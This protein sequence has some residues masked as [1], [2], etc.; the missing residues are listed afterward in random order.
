MRRLADVFYGEATLR[1][2]PSSGQAAIS[3]QVRRGAYQE[4]SPLGALLSAPLQ[5]YTVKAITGLELRT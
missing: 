1:T 2:S 3:S 5:A 4:R